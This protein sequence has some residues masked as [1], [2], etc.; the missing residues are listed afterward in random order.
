MTWGYL[1]SLYFLKMPW[2]TVI[3]S[4]RASEPSPCEAVCCVVCCCPS[5]CERLGVGALPLAGLATA[6]ESGD[7]LTGK[8]AACWQSA[9]GRQSNNIASPSQIVAVTV[10]TSPRCRSIL[11]DGELIL[12]F[13]CGGALTRTTL[14]V[15][16]FLEPT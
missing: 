15:Q 3:R 16:C 7:S 11:T 6:A 5:S 1:C 10:W 12:Q 9:V 2:S 14:Q 13:Y 8:L 4:V